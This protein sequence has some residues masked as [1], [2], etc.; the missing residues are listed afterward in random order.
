[1]S[2]CDIGHRKM[3]FK[4]STLTESTK[5]IQTVRED[6]VISGKLVCSVADL[7]FGKLPRMTHKAIRAKLGDKSFEQI[8][9]KYVRSK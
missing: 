2:I 8:A 4:P 7:K 6:P 3:Y 9:L 5:Q 1:M